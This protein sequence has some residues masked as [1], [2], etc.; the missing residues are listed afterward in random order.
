MCYDIKNNK[1]SY[2]ALVKTCTDSAC[3]AVFKSKIA[4][5]GCYC[6]RVGNLKS[7]ESL[8]FHENKRTQFPEMLVSK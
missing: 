2:I 1:W 6:V 3:C 5:I 4:V 7:V 8:C